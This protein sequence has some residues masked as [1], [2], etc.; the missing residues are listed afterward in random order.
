MINLLENHEY[1][2][3]TV[4]AYDRLVEVIFTVFVKHKKL[5]EQQV[6]FKF[7][8]EKREFLKKHVSHIYRNT[9]Y[10]NIR[11]YVVTQ[12]IKNRH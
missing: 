8:S 7:I 1:E 9:D 10:K 5:K 4:Y 11:V 6:W 12:N 2:V 3:T